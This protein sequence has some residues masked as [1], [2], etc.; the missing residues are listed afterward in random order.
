MLE[1]TPPPGIDRFLGLNNVTDPLRA[2]LGF[3]SQA[4]NVHVTDTG[5]LEV[6]KGYSRVKTGAFSGIFSTFDSKRAY[7]VDGGQLQ[8]LGGVS[9]Q[10]GLN[11]ADMYWSEVNDQVFFNNGVDSGIIQPDN[12]VMPWAWAEP[13]PPALALVTG[14]LDSG[15]YSACVTYTLPDGRETG[16]SDFVTLDVAAG[17]ALQIAPVQVAG[18]RCNVYLTP[19]NSATFYYVASPAGPMVW[20]SAPENMGHELMTGSLSPLPQGCSVIQAWGGRMY[21]AQYFPEL[22]QSAVWFSQPLAFHLFDT[23]ADFFLV[24]GEARMLAPHEQGLVIG[25]DS[26][27]MVYTPTGMAQLADYGVIPGQHWAKDDGRIVFWSERGVCA[28][29]PFA[30]LTESHV[31]VAPGLQAGGV[32]VRSGGQKRYLVALHQGGS[33]FNNFQE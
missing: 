33:A 17:Q 26:R 15:T 4:D 30:N 3:L 18:L 31:S 11:G 29:L 9:L 27:I 16:A 12:T 6:R 28:A 20:N 1:T 21:A 24:P 23:A 25:T 22:N 10:S 19:A 8:T 14:R 5:A 7:L 32:I 2:G 13:V